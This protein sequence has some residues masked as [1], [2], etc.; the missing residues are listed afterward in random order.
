MYYFC[1]TFL[2]ALYIKYILFIERNETFWTR[3][4]ISV[5]VLAHFEFKTHKD[6]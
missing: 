5:R 3:D 4:V 6:F 1:A 2:L